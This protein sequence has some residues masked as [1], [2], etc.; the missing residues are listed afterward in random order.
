MKIIDAHLHFWPE[1]E[2]FTNLALA[3]GHE[4]NA[5]H[6]RNVY[7]E[8]GIVCGIVMGNRSVD[9]GDHVYPDFMR[10]CIGMD[11]FYLTENDVSGSIEN[12]E[13]N[14][15]RT[16]CVGIKLYP[17]YSPIYV[18]DPI[19]EPVYELA[20]RYGKP[21]AVHTGETATPSAYLKYSHPLSLDQAAA[22]H[23]QVQFVM[24]HYGNPWLM[25][26]AAV[27]SKN[28]NVAADISGIL[29]GRVCLERLFEE[30]KGYLE[31][32]RTWMGYLHEYDDLLFGTDWPLANLEEY[33]E[34][35]KRLVPEKYWEKVF[36]DNADRIYQLEL[37]KEI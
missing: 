34:F 37:R 8:L 35:V 3:A 36:F 28:P 23:P 14:L 5:E 7:K 20:K 30:K 2:G 29:E 17:G 18:S 1:E 32:L 16:Q 26:A 6:L 24:C 27:V 10:Y 15:R 21:V 19:Y 9:P 12:L 31:A 25:D 33:I 4:N 22:E 13:K 11:S